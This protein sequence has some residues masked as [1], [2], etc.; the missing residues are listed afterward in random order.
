MRGKRITDEPG[1]QEWGIS[2]GQ[3]QFPKSRAIVVDDE[4]I[5]VRVIHSMLTRIGFTVDK[6]G[7]G[8]E[9][10]AL[11]ERASYE[12]VVTD[13]RMPRL[14]GYELAKLIKEQ[15]NGTVVVMITGS[16]LKE[17]TKSG[18]Y[19]GPLDAWL[20]KPFD[21][22]EFIDLVTVLTSLPGEK[23]PC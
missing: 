16:S 21:H 15:Y 5:M 18:V 8:L 3:S 17:V 4:P 20:F 23:E 1:S 6:A 10:K 2:K 22:L 11:L 9:A 14:N 7:D 13:F 19:P 12:L